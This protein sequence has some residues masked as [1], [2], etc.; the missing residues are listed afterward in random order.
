MLDGAVPHELPPG[1]LA[2]IR[3]P[4]DPMSIAAEISFHW[5]NARSKLRKASSEGGG[6]R[7]VCCDG[8]NE[9]SPP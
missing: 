5:W 7:G 8:N 4:L 6:A 9:F 2:A 3:K 1:T